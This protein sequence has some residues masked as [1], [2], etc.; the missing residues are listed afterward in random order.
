[1]VEAARSD[2]PETVTVLDC[3][4][5]S[6]VFLVGT[7]HFS[8]SSVEDVKKTINTVR[9]KWCVVIVRKCV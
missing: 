8:P 4:N 2:L 9:E 5:G 6:R 3:P 1:M 7:A